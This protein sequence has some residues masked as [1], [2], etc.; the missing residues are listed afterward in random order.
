MRTLSGARASGRLE[1][2]TSN[3]V[4]LIVLINIKT[5]KTSAATE[6]LASRARPGVLCPFCALELRFRALEDQEYSATLSRFRSP[7]APFRQTYWT[8]LQAYANDLDV[9]VVQKL[10]QHARLT[11]TMNMCAH[12]ISDKSAKFSVA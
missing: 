10:M 3:R 5:Y 2:P 4:N 12:M 6:S 1:L 7:N 9:K 8:L 11:T